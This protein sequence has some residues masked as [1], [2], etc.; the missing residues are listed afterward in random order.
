MQYCSVSYPFKALEK[1][2]YDQFSRHCCS[3]I[4][5]GRGTETQTL[6]HGLVFMT[7]TVT[8][9]LTIPLLRPS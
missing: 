3:I 4:P 5:L 9:G 1:V 7:V 6:V 8:R 2:S